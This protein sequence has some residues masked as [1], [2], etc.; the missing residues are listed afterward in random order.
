MRGSFFSLSWVVWWHTNQI[1]SDGQVDVTDGYIQVSCKHRDDGIIHAAA[2]R[3][4][5][6]RDSGNKGYESLFPK[7]K[8]GVNG[9]G[10]SNDLSISFFWSLGT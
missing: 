6:G 3:R 4:E 5:E 9:L 1:C 10:V 8:D 7:G 2:Q